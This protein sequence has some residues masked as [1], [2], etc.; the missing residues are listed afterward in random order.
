MK[1]K[2]LTV[3]PFPLDGTLFKVVKATDTTEYIPG[4]TITKRDLD[5][6]CGYSKWKITIVENR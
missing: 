3:A 1:T 4:H 6:L 5:I 2:T